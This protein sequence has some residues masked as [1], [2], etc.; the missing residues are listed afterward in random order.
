MHWVLSS[1]CYL[2][3]KLLFD[4]IWC[5]I[6][7]IILCKQW[8]ESIIEFD[9]AI[10]LYL[11]LTHT[12]THNMSLC[13]LEYIMY[14]TFKEKKRRNLLFENYILLL[15]NL[16]KTSQKHQVVTSKKL[17]NI[18]RERESVY[19]CVWWILVLKFFCFYYIFIFL[20]KLIVLTK[21]FKVHN[22]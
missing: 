5:W 2:A 20:L 12:H 19:V 11:S 9:M 18:Q 7:I 8:T 3:A 14:I 16:N 13:M 22:L 10:F 6:V 17:Q 1:N 4:L 15:S 21:H